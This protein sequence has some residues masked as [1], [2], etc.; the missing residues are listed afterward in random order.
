MF[1]YEK[2]FPNTPLPYPDLPYTFEDAN[3]PA[4]GEQVDWRKSSRY[5]SKVASNARMTGIADEL[6]K[7]T[8]EG[9][10][11]KEMPAVFSEVRSFSNTSVVKTNEGW[12]LAMGNNGK[13]LREF[14]EPENSSEL[15]LPQGVPLSYLQ[16]RALQTGGFLQLNKG[17]L[18]QFGYDK[19]DEAEWHFNEKDKSQI[20]GLVNSYS[21]FSSR[22]VFLPAQIAEIN[23]GAMG[24]VAAGISRESV[25]VDTRLAHDDFE[26]EEEVSLYRDLIGENNLKNLPSAVV[27]VATHEYGHLID[28]NYQQNS[29]DSNKEKEPLYSRMGLKQHYEYSQQEYVDNLFRDTLYKASPS[30]HFADAF[31]MHH[32]GAMATNTTLPANRDSYLSLKNSSAKN[33]NALSRKMSLDA[34]RLQETLQ[35]KRQR[36]LAQENYKRAQEYARTRKTANDEQLQQ[37]YAEMEKRGNVSNLRMS[38]ASGFRP[39]AIQ[40]EESVRGRDPRTVSITPTAKGMFVNLGTGTNELGG[41]YITRNKKTANLS[42]SEL[43]ARGLASKGGFSKW[44][45]ANSVT[46]SDDEDQRGRH[47]SMIQNAQGMRRLESSMGLPFMKDRAR[48][49]RDMGLYA[50]GKGKTGYRFSEFGQAINAF[51]DTNEDLLRRLGMTGLGITNAPAFANIKAKRLANVGRVDSSL[52]SYKGQVLP[53]RPDVLMGGTVQTVMQKRYM[54]GVQFAE[55]EAEKIA[56]LHSSMPQQY[57]VPTESIGGLQVGQYYGNLHGLGIDAQSSGG[58]RALRNMGLRVSNS[59]DAHQIMDIIHDEK[60]GMSTIIANRMHSKT[61]SKAWEKPAHVDRDAGLMGKIDSDSPWAKYGEG[62]RVHVQ[63]RHTNDLLFQARNAT[64]G[65]FAILGEDAYE[66]AISNFISAN[67]DALEGKHIADAFAMEYYANGIEHDGKRIGGFNWEQT[68]ATVSSDRLRQYM[69]VAEDTP[70]DTTGWEQ[71]EDGKWYRTLSD[72]GVTKRVIEKV[73][74]NKDGDLNVLANDL[75]HTSPT[76]IELSESFGTGKHY[77]TAPSMMA[78][79][80]TDPSFARVLGDFDKAGVGRASAY[81]HTLA[82]V[83][84]RRESKDGEQYL[85]ELGHGVVNI[86]DIDFAGLESRVKTMG[87]T[88][89]KRAEAMLEALDE[90]YPNKFIGVKG[91]ND[92]AFFAPA[93]EM[94]KMLTED[95]EGDTFSNLAGRFASLLDIAHE[96]KLG[97]DGASGEF[98]RAVGDVVSEQSEYVAN[99]NVKANAMSMRLPAITGHAMPMRGGKANQVVMWMDEIERLTGMSKKEI[100]EN[101]GNKSLSMM[102]TRYPESDQTAALIGA[103]IVLADKLNKRQRKSRGVSGDKSQVLISTAIQDALVGDFD[104][105][106]VSG[107]LNMVKKGNQ[108]IGGNTTINTE[109]EIRK[110]RD[111]RFGNEYAGLDEK[112]TARANASDYMNEQANKALTRKSESA[113]LNEISTAI[114]GKGIIGK[115][116]NAGVRTFDAWAGEVLSN[117]S[118]PIAGIMRKSVGS[119]GQGLYQPALDAKFQRGMEQISDLMYGYADVDKGQVALRTTPGEHRKHF[120]YSEANRQVLNMFGQLVAGYENEGDK[121]LM[122]R[123]LAIS[124]MSPNHAQ[125]LL[126]DS[127]F[128]D[129][130]ASIEN[131]LVGLGADNE[132]GVDEANQMYDQLLGANRNGARPF[133][134][135]NENPALGDSSLLGGAIAGAIG[136]R[137]EE[138]A[139]KYGFS[140]EM[141]S[142]YMKQRGQMMADLNE[143]TKALIPNKNFRRMPSAMLSDVLKKKYGAVST[144]LAQRFGDAG[145]L[146]GISDVPMNLAMD[147]DG[148]VPHPTKGLAYMNRGGRQMIAN[149]TYGKNPGSVLD[150]DSANAISMSAL[151]P[152]FKETESQWQKRLSAM[153]AIPKEWIMGAYGDNSPDGQSLVSMT[154]A[155]LGLQ[156]KSLGNSDESTMGT[157]IHKDIQRAL[158]GDRADIEHVTRRMVNGRSQK[159]YNPN[160]LAELEVEQDGIRG[161][162]DAVYNGMVLDV[163][164]K[165]NFSGVTEQTSVAG[166][167]PQMSAIHMQTVEGRGSVNGNTVNATGVMPVPQTEGMS[168]KERMLASADAVKKLVGQMRGA[169]QKDDVG[170]AGQ[171]LENLYGRKYAGE[172]NFNLEKLADYIETVNNR[173]NENGE[174]GMGVVPVLGKEAVEFGVTD[175]NLAERMYDETKQLTEQKYAWNANDAKRNFGATARTLLGRGRESYQSFLKQFRSQ[176]PETFVLPAFSSGTPRKTNWFSLGQRITVDPNEDVT[177]TDG[178]VVEVKQ[179][180]TMNNENIARIDRPDQKAGLLDP[181]EK[182]PMSRSGVIAYGKAMQ[183]VYGV[184]P[185]DEDG[186]TLSPNLKPQIGAS[187]LKQLGF[188]EEQQQSLA[189]LTPFEL[190]RSGELQSLIKGDTL[191]TIQRGAIGDFARGSADMIETARKAQARSGIQ[192]DAYASQIRGINADL[193]DE[194][195]K[196]ELGARFSSAGNLTMQKSAEVGGLLGGTGDK[197]ADKASAQ[198]G[199]FFDKT[200]KASDSFINSLQR[201]EKGFN[202]G[203]KAYEEATQEFGVWTDSLKKFQSAMEPVLSAQ[204]QFGQI[205]AEQFESLKGAM[206]FRQGADGSREIAPLVG[207]DAQGNQTLNTDVYLGTTGHVK[208]QL[209]QTMG[210][211]EKATERRSQKSWQEMV[212]LSHEGRANVRRLQD[213]WQAPDE[214]GTFTEGAFAGMGKNLGTQ[215][216]VG[217]TSVLSSAMNPY[218]LFAA[219]RIWGMTGKQGMSA[220]DVYQKSATQQQALSFYGGLISGDQLV[221]GQY[222]TIMGRRGRQAEATRAFGQNV[223][224]AFG[225]LRDMIM[226]PSGGIMGGLTG[227]GVPAIGAGLATASLLKTAVGG[228]MFGADAMAKGMVGWGG[229]L[230]LGV[231]GATALAGGLSYMSNAGNNLDMIAGGD[232]FAQIGAGIG[233]W[234]GGKNLERGATYRNISNNA[235]SYFRGGSGSIESMQSEGSAGGLDNV[236]VQNA[237]QRG[238]KEVYKDRG[239]KLYGEN[240]DSELQSTYRLAQAVDP[241]F[242][243][244]TNENLTNRIMDLGAKYGGVEEVSKMMVGYGNALGVDRPTLGMVNEASAYLAQ[245]GDPLIGMARFQSMQGAM[246]SANQYR[247]LQGQEG[248]GLS[249]FSQFT[250]AQMPFVGQIQGNIAQTQFNSRY[251]SGG[252]IPSAINSALGAGDFKTAQRLTNEFQLASGLSS[253]SQQQIQF[254]GGD[255]GAQSTA[256]LLI[257]GG[258]QYYGDTGQQYLQEL[259]PILT[260]YATQSSELAGLAKNKTLLEQANSGDSSALGQLQASFPAE[261]ELSTALSTSP[262][263]AMSR[264]T[265]SVGFNINGQIANATENIFKPAS[266]FQAQGGNLSAL[267]QRR[268]I[269]S[270]NGMGYENYASSSKSV[271]DS[272]ATASPDELLGFISESQSAGFLNQSDQFYGGWFGRDTQSMFNGI[273]LSDPTRQQRQSTL[274]G[275]LG[276]FF[277]NNAGI[278]ETGRNALLQYAVGNGALSFDPQRSQNAFMMTNQV[279]GGFGQLQQQGFYT[280]QDNMLNAMTGI[281]ATQP[282][283]PL[284]NRMLGMTGDALNA[285]LYRTNRANLG[286]VSAVESGLLSS[287]SGTDWGNPA[288]VQ[289]LSAE[290]GTSSFRLQAG[291]MGRASGMGES[292]FLDASSLGNDDLMTDSIRQSA[293]RLFQE[294]SGVLIEN[295]SLSK[296]SQKAVVDMVLGGGAEMYGDEQ[297]VEGR[298]RG[299]AR[300]STAMN[301]LSRYQATGSSADSLSAMALQTFGMDS[302]QFAQWQGMESQNPYVM[303]QNLA[304][305]QSR[306]GSGAVPIAPMN[307]QTGMATT[308][309][310]LAPGGNK[311][312]LSALR[313]V[314]DTYKGSFLAPYMTDDYLANIGGVAGIQGE[315]SNL[316]MSSI[317][318]S[319]GH[320]R[321]ML[322]MRNAMNMGGGTLDNQGYVVGGSLAG[323]QQQ[324]A[325][326]GFNFNT[327]NGM[328]AWQIDDRKSQMSR[329][330]QMWGLEKSGR[331]K[332]MEK[333]QF[334][335]KWNFGKQQ[336][337]YN[338]TYQR[339]EMQIGR[340]QQ[341]TQR[342]WT[343]DDMAFSRNQQVTQFAWQREDNSFS[344]A[345]NALEFGWQTEDYGRNLKY[346]RGR[347]R[348]NLLREQERANVRYSMDTGQADKQDSRQTQQEQW[349]DEQFTKQMNRFNQQVIWEDQRFERTIEHFNI[350]NAYELEQML[351]QKRHF[352]EKMGL[353]DEDYEKNKA[354]TLEMMALEDQERLLSRQTSL[355]FSEID[356]RFSESMAGVQR[357]IAELSNLLT[358]ISATDQW[359]EGL[360]NLRQ[361]V[362]EAPTSLVGLP[363]A[364]AGFANKARGGASLDEFATRLSSDDGTGGTE[365]LI[366]KWEKLNGVVAN[367]GDRLDPFAKIIGNVGNQAGKSRD[368]LDET[369]KRFEVVANAGARLGSGL[370]IMNAQMGQASANFDNMANA[371]GKMA[372]VGG[373]GNIDALRASFDTLSG[374]LPV[375]DGALG[376]TQSALGQFG[377]M[378][379]GVAQATYEA[380]AQLNAAGAN[381]PGKAYGGYTGDPSTGFAKGGYTGDG[382]KFQPAGIVHKGEW[383]VPQGGALVMREGAG[384]DTRLFMEML[385]ELMKIREELKAI[386]AMGPGRVNAVINTNMNEIK[387]SA[388]TDNDRVRAR[389]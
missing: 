310:Q 25:F 122:A 323:L 264:F 288:Q 248:L 156:P 158:L 252:Y 76:A 175:T 80:S 298:S 303:S 205:S 212:G 238:F 61:A 320:G 246:Q 121:R 266:N 150:E 3:K 192:S 94:R 181:Y 315:I 39:G 68:T 259:Q 293:G 362:N 168:A 289:A 130:V 119:I 88:G 213:A 56:G 281:N 363:T 38:G 277:G 185:F 226:N 215:L 81:F 85:N 166:Y 319:A 74:K 384:S 269:Q 383:V 140:T 299:L 253:V 211:A 382:S 137:T 300:Y 217:A 327:G 16:A 199:A 100:M 41:H 136:A 10:R 342:A 343:Q 46:K 241:S 127:S 282:Q 154:R 332:E 386:K 115:M 12:A 297:A 283:Y 245:S 107:I 66:S 312:F 13:R 353:A 83:A 374:S 284:V 2:I 339:E 262:T 155:G 208:D 360:R 352:E 285:R 236:D 317:G 44:V 69:R 162:L 294:F 54:M 30:E 42:N 346:A 131:K 101:V 118:R 377:S 335:E 93:R 58:T 177:L 275:S 149:L 111:T 178:A 26:S 331:D 108:L 133:F 53:M 22:P 172:A 340:T 36:E 52:A 316:Q 229:P 18:N 290:L 187:R 233:E 160:A 225:G 29:I 151:N 63:T 369:A 367:S 35:I 60:T 274:M 126:D 116:F 62:G 45:L 222:G 378:I 163:K 189:N 11:A 261:L 145:N 132:F 380:I 57:Q 112:L 307:L 216:R 350:I 14:S 301:S 387:T 161:K 272:L 141:M 295:A 336:F 292:A 96:K 90:L 152:E 361:A 165:K 129:T 326:Q 314:N 5:F 51:G 19:G 224:T 182:M 125:S 147:A 124:M 201:M 204:I 8:W 255:K 228:G 164:S 389:I 278:S 256:D 227:V 219:N 388:I 379:K 337:D 267:V 268:M 258:A 286:D 159:V 244:L 17:E 230:A 223:D 345:R 23:N 218:N 180:G 72:G 186:E 203:G 113:Y 309:T 373:S 92:T 265:S 308:M 109:A 358:G 351:M 176:S 257:S 254:M 329:E 313:G 47:V 280:N 24:F 89:F 48:E 375:L 235:S 344:R 4:D 15:G 34:S 333:R 139:Q 173:L 99:S 91:G 98:A 138:N 321:R 306:W 86:E 359:I 196:T 37:M 355:A 20:N 40:F 220:M 148:L 82:D 70:E 381:M 376:T 232:L 247:I 328:T 322:N 144:I 171:I 114:K 7:S 9:F 65:A 6:E 200:G 221:D 97:G 102:V 348:I 33:S 330:M 271:I 193:F 183:S 103:E 365:G 67:K 334:Y 79:Q 105:D 190:L 174:W 195:T 59:P 240:Y 341:L 179:R 71:D 354:H 95:E 302:Q 191:N 146:R 311:G 157:A 198:L 237:I 73:W 304:G 349:A 49:V 110:M 128:K 231:A 276:G 385:S 202:A 372:G 370:S 368:V 366:S 291:I 273:D 242:S 123:N 170:M 31:M 356:Q 347:D 188:G 27:R 318:A 287:V 270:G 43:L 84:S 364:E 106:Q 143:K 371:L 75:V 206:G 243:M 21:P 239:Q 249:Y 28:T 305:A 296:T 117:D 325:S 32:V 279:I 120:D 134:N 209:N 104:K 210:I 251:Q 214:G 169:V 142:P 338:T 87:G 77:I 263:D 50:T 207:Y 135:V 250:Q 1:P 324:L 78:R 197:Q 357:K 167:M 55:G 153:S 234:T 260:A 64:R 184:N 194:E